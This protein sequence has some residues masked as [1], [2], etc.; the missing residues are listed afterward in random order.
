MDAAPLTAIINELGD[1]TTAIREAPP[2]HKQAVY[3]HLGLRLTYQP[4]T[5]TVLTEVDLGQDRWQ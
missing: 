1:L 2:E 4:D 5:R 3:Q